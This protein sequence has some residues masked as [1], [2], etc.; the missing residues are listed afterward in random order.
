MSKRNTH[1][2]AD[3][4]TDG[5]L[6]IVDGTHY[7]GK[8]PKFIELKLPDGT[9]FWHKVAK[10]LPYVKVSPNNTRTRA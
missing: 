5:D 9:A 3:S 4:L 7:R 6:I 1:A 2:T 8:P 10:G